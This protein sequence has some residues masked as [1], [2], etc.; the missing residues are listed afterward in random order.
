MLKR[1]VV[2]SSGT[3]SNFRNIKECVDK[4]QING[5]IVLLISNNPKCEA[6]NFS[7]LN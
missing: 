7:K 5:K 3:G 2:F 4:K 6:V 1:I